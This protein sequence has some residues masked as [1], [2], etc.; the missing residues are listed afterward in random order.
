[1]AGVDVDALAARLQND[2]ANS[3]V[4]SGNELIAVI[5]SES[6]ALNER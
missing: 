2:G 3:F 4:A 6:A 5:G 1:M